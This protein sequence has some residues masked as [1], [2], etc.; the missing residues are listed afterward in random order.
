M[1]TEHITA[2]LQS[3]LYAARQKPAGDTRDGQHTHSVQGNALIVGIPALTV[4]PMG[5][6]LNAV[7][8]V[9]TAARRKYIPMKM[10]VQDI[11]STVM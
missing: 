4:F 11:I 9:R 5:P 1:K 8:H 3:V 2:I 10:S 7:T 6:V